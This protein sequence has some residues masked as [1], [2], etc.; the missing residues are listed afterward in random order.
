[1]R[2]LRIVLFT[3][4]LIAS[5]FGCIDDEG[6]AMSRNKYLKQ[7][8]QYKSLKGINSNLLS[9]DIYYFKKSYEPKPVVIYVH[10]GGWCLGDKANQITNKT[11]LFE[12]QGYIFVSVNYRLSPYPYQTGTPGRIKYPDHNYDIAD[13]VK[14]IY[15]NISK[16]G[17]DKNR[18]VLL[19]HSAGAHLVSLTGTNEKFLKSRGLPMTVIKGIASIDTKAYDVYGQIHNSSALKMMYINAFGTD[20]VKNIE[21]SPLYNVREGIQYPAFFIALRGSEQRKEA[22]F[23]F[24]EKLQKYEV[25]VTW[26]DGSMYDHKG[27]NNAIGDKDDTVIT[28]AL[29]NFFKSCFR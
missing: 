3:Y 11:N 16:Y 18:I 2:I 10:G 1:M 14:W 22:S 8:V 4:F 17:G 15:D 21:A 19:G 7:T 9:L 29:I 5:S 12:K 23:R 20:S 28:P 13:A 25:R 6:I 26:V 27:I 24:I